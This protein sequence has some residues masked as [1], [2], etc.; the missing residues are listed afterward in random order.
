MRNLGDDLYAVI[1]LGVVL[2]IGVAFVG[3]MVIGYVVYAL[4]C[5]F[6]G[7]VPAYV[8]Y[9]VPAF[10]TPAENTSWNT[11]WAENS[12]DWYLRYGGITNSSNSIIGGFDNAVALI[13]V[14][15]TIF[16]LAIAISALLLLRGRQG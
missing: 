1:D 3:L 13:L 10:H 11:S 5:Q 12:T 7:T 15:V 6:M 8:P 16:I 9:T 14:A 4:Y 2:M